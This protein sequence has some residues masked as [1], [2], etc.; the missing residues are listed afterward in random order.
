MKRYRPGC[1]L[2]GRLPE[3]QGDFGD[4]ASETARRSQSE[5]V[6]ADVVA[7]TD[8]DAAET[9]RGTAIADDNHV[10]AKHGGVYSLEGDFLAA[11]PR[12]ADSDGPANLVP[13]AEILAE[14]HPTVEK[15]LGKPAHIGEVHGGANDNARDLGQTYAGLDGGEVIALAFAQRNSSR[16]RAL[17]FE[18][19]EIDEFC[20]NPRASF[21]RGF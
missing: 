4:T 7:A 17:H 2:R 20:F 6:F 8:K 3:T 18:A 9:G 13:E 10:L 19:T 14:N 1:C 16:Q 12:G 11:I 21:F 5:F 15:L